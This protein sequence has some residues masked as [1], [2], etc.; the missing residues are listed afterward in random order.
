MAHGGHSGTS[1]R[2]VARVCVSG[3]RVMLRAGYTQCRSHSGHSRRGRRPAEAGD[4]TFTPGQPWERGP[5]PLRPPGPGPPPEP[6]RATLSCLTEARCRT[7]RHGPRPSSPLASGR[8]A[9]NPVF[10]LDAQGRTV[11][12]AQPGADVGQGRWHLEGCLRVCRVR[13]PYVRVCRRSRPAGDGLLWW[14]RPQ[15]T[16]GCRL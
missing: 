10:W 9:W 16:A 12:M 6:L 3:L 4:A 1:V 13:S 14:R 15:D 11:S 8:P 5:R 7:R 2:L